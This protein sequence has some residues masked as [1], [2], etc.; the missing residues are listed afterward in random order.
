MQRR[1]LA[2]AIRALLQHQENECPHCTKP[3]T[4]P[5]LSPSFLAPPEFF[6]PTS[7][8]AQLSLIANANKTQLH[9]L[10]IFLPGRLWEGFAHPRIWINVRSFRR[11]IL[12]TTSPGGGAAVP[13]KKPIGGK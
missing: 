4:R 1:G 2:G 8:C 6:S 9:L 12:S 13:G 3:H 7:L 11:F 5:R 10:A